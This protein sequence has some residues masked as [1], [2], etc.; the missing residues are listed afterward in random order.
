M[1]LFPG[2]ISSGLILKSWKGFLSKVPHLLVKN[3]FADRHFAYRPLA[4]KCLA[5]RHLKKRQL[6]S[7]HLDDGDLTN[8]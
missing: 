2:L 8:R 3:Y 4:D 6:V 7:G 1:T 5:N